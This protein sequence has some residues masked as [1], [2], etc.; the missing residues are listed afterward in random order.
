MNFLR[1]R[2]QGTEISFPGLEY[3]VGRGKRFPLNRFTKYKRQMRGTSMPQENYIPPIGAPHLGAACA[4]AGEPEPRS[5]RVR[6]ACLPAGRWTTAGAPTPIPAHFCPI[7]G[8][9]PHS[10]MERQLAWHHR[11][12]R[13]G[14]GWYRTDARCYGGQCPCLGECLDTLRAHGFNIDWIISTGGGASSGAW[15]QI[16]ADVSGLTVSRPATGHGAAQGASYLAGMA[17]GVRSSASELKALSA[18]ETGRFSP[19]PTL[20]ESYVAKRERFNLVS[21]LNTKRGAPT[22]PSLHSAS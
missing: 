17:V 8:R 6:A 22:S 21:S 18:E 15:L 2:W 7:T 20:K 11:R 12:N 13:F 19:D 1:H 5:I 16:K 14:H 3:E 9:G 4:R 10:Y